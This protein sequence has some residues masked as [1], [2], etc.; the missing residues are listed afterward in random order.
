VVERHGHGGSA[1]Q[2]VYK[3]ARDGTAGLLGLVRE[4]KGRVEEMASIWRLQ[5]RP[6]GLDRMR[7]AVGTDVVRRVASGRRA[8]R[9]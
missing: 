6:A 3:T 8:A 1:L 5:G 4:Q 9:A 2:R 7:A